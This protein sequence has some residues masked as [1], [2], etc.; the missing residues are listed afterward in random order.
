VLC[1]TCSVS[2]SGAFTVT[3]VR[4]R[5]RHGTTARARRLTQRLESAWRLL[6]GALRT[7]PAASPGDGTIRPARLG[8]AFFDAD[9]RRR[10]RFEEDWIELIR[11]LPS[12]LRWTC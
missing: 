6:G 8:D 1:N 12:S 4:V 3:L 11:L 9:V 10:M 2:S 7:T 5:E